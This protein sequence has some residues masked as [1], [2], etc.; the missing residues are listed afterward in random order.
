MKLCEKCRQPMISAGSICHRASCSPQMVEKYLPA[1]EHGKNGRR[2]VQL[3][4]RDDKLRKKIA[5]A[6]KTFYF[7]ACAPS[8]WPYLRR[9]L[10]DIRDI[11]RDMYKPPVRTREFI[12]QV[13]NAGRGGSVKYTLRSSSLREHL[14]VRGAEFAQQVL[15]EQRREKLTREGVNG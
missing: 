4:D 6:S 7:W 2:E 14:A 1:V 15:A 9:G 11:K 8:S 5:P 12:G 13:S 3:F 10:A